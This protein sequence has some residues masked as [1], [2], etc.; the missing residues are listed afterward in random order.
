MEAASPHVDELAEIFKVLGDP[1]RLRILTALIGAAG[2]CVHDI[3]TRVEVSQ[4]AVSH[5]LRILRGAR[6]VRGRRSGREIIYT[7][8]DEHVLALMSTGLT[9]AGHGSRT[10]GKRGK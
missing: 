8:D 5:Q 7:L 4:P 9:H 2:L 1:T 10:T 6:L 3:C